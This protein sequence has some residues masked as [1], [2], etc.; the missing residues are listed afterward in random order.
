MDKELMLQYLRDIKAGL[1][2]KAYARRWKREYI[3]GT[4]VVLDMLIED[5][6][7]GAFDTRG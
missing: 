4:I 1:E 2:E 7:R 5:I 3:R 6:E